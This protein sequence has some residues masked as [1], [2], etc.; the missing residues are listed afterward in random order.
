MLRFPRQLAALTGLLVFTTI[1]LNGT[2]VFAPPSANSTYL[3]NLNYSAESG[4]QSAVF[5]GRD[6][7]NSMDTYRHLLGEYDEKRAY[8]L[9]NVYDEASYSRRFSELAASA[10]HDLESFHTRAYG[11]RFAGQLA[12]ELNIKALI[13]SKSPLLIFGALAAVYTGRVI[14][15]RLSEQI[16]VETRSSFSRSHFE[17]QYLGWRHATSGTSIGTN[18]GGA[19]TSVSMSQQITPEIAVTYDKRADHSV[20]VRYTQG[21]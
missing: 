9:L 11:K 8:G 17:E 2:R 7:W 18:F 16:V 13:E 20:G 21:F 1:Y 3:S 15:Y 10:L 6:R 14:R 12:E 4:W 19:A 5:G